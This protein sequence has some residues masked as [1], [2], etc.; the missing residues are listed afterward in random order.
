MTCQE[1]ELALAGEERISVVDERVEAHMA[2]CAGCRE[3]AVELREN[4]EALQAFAMETLP[5]LKVSAQELPGV[6]SVG[7]HGRQYVA[8]WAAIAAVLVLG[9]VSSWVMLRPRLARLSAPPV[10]SFKTP[11]AQMA[12]AE[13]IKQG[14]AQAIL[15]PAGFETVPA[16]VRRHIARRPQHA[17]REALEINNE[18]RIL[19]VKMLT[20][21][22]DVVIYWQIEN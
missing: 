4:S 11:S 15:S 17:P 9:F 16:P 2:G 1:C 20:D 22:P 8:W 3:F 13:S 10:L 21:D 14:V 18:P 19:Q 5:G 7:Q 6:G 12:S